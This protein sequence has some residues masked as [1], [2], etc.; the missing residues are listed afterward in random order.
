MEAKKDNFAVKIFEPFQIKNGTM[1]QY[2]LYTSVNE[3]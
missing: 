1:K 3:L 2:T